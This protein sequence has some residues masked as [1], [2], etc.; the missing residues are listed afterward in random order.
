MRN[1][2]SVFLIC[3]PLLCTCQD[4]R[5]PKTIPLT[6][7]SVEIEKYLGKW[8]EV[9]RFP[10]RFEKGLVGVTA[11]Y[12]LRDD[13]KIEVV[14]A[15]YKNSFQGKF[16]EA[17]GLAKIPDKKDASK[18]KVSFFL[19]FYADYYILEL[20][21]TNYQYALVGSSSDDYLW[22]LSRNPLIADETYTMLVEKAKA[23]GY[24]VEKLIKVEQKLTID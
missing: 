16:K 6:V 4:K 5:M 12:T 23:R 10:H 3:I 18:L 7:K 1:H 14:N 22:I 21:T 11:T 13:G 8:Y 20:D 17:H 2:L 9:A 19:F 15:G 24:Q